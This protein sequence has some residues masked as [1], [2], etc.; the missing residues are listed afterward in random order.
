MKYLLDTCLVLW[1]LDGNKQKLKKFSSIIEDPANELAISVIS[2]WEIT[3]K[4]TLGKLEI[5]DNWTNAVE[6]TGLVWL[7]L[8]PKHIQQLETLPPIHHDPFD[9]LLISQA[10]AEQMIILTSD[11]KILQYQA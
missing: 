2:Y 9:R 5:P 6:E 10:K 7:N 3:I 11:D 4:K 1:M 8:E